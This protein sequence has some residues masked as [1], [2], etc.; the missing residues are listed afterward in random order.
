MSWLPNRYNATILILGTRRVS[1]PSPLMC[2]G[3]DID[4]NVEF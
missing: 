3:I 4:L 2:D 1:Y